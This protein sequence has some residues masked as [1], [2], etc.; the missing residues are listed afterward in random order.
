MLLNDNLND[1]D[2]IMKQMR[3]LY[4]R[5]NSVLRKFAACSFD[6]KLRLFQAVCTSFYC[7]HQWYKFTKHVISKV[8]VAYNNVVRLL[9]GYR[10]SCSAGEMFV[11]N[12]IYN[13]E[14]RLRTNSIDFTMRIGSSSNILIAT[15]RENSFT[16][17]GPLRQKCIRSV[18]TIYNFCGHLLTTVPC[19][20]Y[21]VFIYFCRVCYAGAPGRT[22]LR[23][24]GVLLGKYDIINK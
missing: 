5:A 2:D 8:R 17:T 19:F 3:G 6:V 7:A 20:M 4:A 14:G 24:D 1:N 21:C 23:T 9:C 16:L 22:V 11:N 13:F 10:R 12:N 15:L 18:Y